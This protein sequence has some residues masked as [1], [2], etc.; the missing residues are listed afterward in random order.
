MQ[1]RRITKFSF[2]FQLIGICLSDELD[3]CF[4]IWAKQGDCD[5]WIDSCRSVYWK[6]VKCSDSILKRKRKIVAEGCLKNEDQL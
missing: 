6:G 2:S 4:T 1:K 3:N 5:D